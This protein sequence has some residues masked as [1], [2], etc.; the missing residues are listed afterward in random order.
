MSE[1][2]VLSRALAQLVA[3]NCEYVGT[4]APLVELGAFCNYFLSFLD[5]LLK[6]YRA[7]K[8]FDT[9]LAK[10][11]TELPRLGELVQSQPKFKEAV[12]KVVSILSDFESALDQDIKIQEIESIKNAYLALIST[13]MRRARAEICLVTTR[14]NQSSELVKAERTMDTWVKKIV[15]P[16]MT[17][18]VSAIDPLVITV[19]GCEKME[20]FLRKHIKPYMKC[21][22]QQRADVFAMP[23]SCPCFCSECWEFE[24]DQPVDVCP[25]CCKAITGFVTVT[26]D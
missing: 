26:H 17:D 2:T 22:C 24:K 6:A 14:Q 21:F 1:G 11:R 18:E 12:D 16:L 5:T 9:A 4:D 23:C 10:C 15:T 8:D 3:G 20:V 13:K 25:R 19:D 7:A